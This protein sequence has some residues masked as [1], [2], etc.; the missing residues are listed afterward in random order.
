MSLSNKI[1]SSLEAHTLLLLYKSLIWLVLEYGNIVWDPRYKFDQLALNKVQRCAIKLVPLLYN[2]PYNERLHM[3][4][5]PSLYYK[6]RRVDM[7]TTY[8]ILTNEVN[9]D[10]TQFFKGRHHL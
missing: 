3:L 4:G 9:I 5:L 2:H 8:N 7:I 10:Q 6:H 1:F